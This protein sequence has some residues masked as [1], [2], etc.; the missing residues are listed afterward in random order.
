MRIVLAILVFVFLSGC[1]TTSPTAPTSETPAPTN[2]R[3]A[4]VNEIKQSFFDP[5]SIR[6]AAISRP[7]YANGVYDGVSPFP[8]KGWVVCMRGNARNRM[9]GY[10]GLQNTVILFDG[11]RVA[12]SLSGPDYRWQVVELCKNAE[13]EPFPEIEATGASS[14]GTPS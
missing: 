6:D 7:F 14:S 12:M 1:T 2:Y 5:Y 10:T 8:R 11:E 4:V 13:F 9:G 3:E